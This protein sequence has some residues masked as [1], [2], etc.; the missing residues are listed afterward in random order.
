MS[1]AGRRIPWATPRRGLPRRVTGVKLVEGW[2]LFATSFLVGLSGAVMPGPLLTVA[3]ARTGNLG[4]WS[5]LVASAGHGVPEALLVVGLALG[6]GGVLRIALVGGMIAVAGG[7]IL[8]WMAWG[9]FRSSAIVAIS[10]VPGKATS[11]GGPGAAVLRR[12]HH[13]DV[14]SGMGAGA[15]ASISNPYWVL[16]WATIGAGYVAQALSS[17]W[18]GLGLFFGGHILSDVLWLTMVSGAIA[19]GS[20]FLSRTFYAGLIRVL[21]GFLVLLAVYFLIAGYRLLVG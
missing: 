17:G 7:L 10:S 9:M 14:L 4:A 11:G 16:W 3:I 21:A 12:P 20:S 13:L 5:G 2:G 8:A 18:L 19:V 1:A 6:F 15:M